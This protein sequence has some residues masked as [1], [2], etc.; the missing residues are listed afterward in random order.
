ML[1]EEL[2]LRKWSAERYSTRF[3]FVFVKVSPIDKCC[4]Q[5]VEHFLEIL[6]RLDLAGPL[7]LLCD[8]RIVGLAEAAPAI[9]EC[10]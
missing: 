1:H 8:R 9:G 3:G 7:A 5:F 10:D 2:L 6:H 4:V